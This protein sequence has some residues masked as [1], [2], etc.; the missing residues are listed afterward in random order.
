MRRPPRAPDA[1]LLDRALV[2][3]I[4]L[5]GVLIL[6]GAFGLFAWALA[7]GRT[8]AEARTIAVNVFVM[9]ELCYLFNCRSLTLPFWRLGW[10]SNPWVWAGAG[11]MAALQLLFTYLPAM[12]RLFGSAPIGARDWLLIALCG[13]IASGV[14]GVEKA[15]RRR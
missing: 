15:W 14:V 4:V 7:D 6:A 9:I 1:A 3:R 10:F 12:N 8:P 13:L 5:V 11:A 2:L